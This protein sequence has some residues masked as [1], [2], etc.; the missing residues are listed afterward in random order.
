MEV[1]PYA[2]IQSLKEQIQTK[3]I[4]PGDEQLFDFEGQE[5][6]QTVLDYFRNDRDKLNYLPLTIRRTEIQIWV[7]PQNSEPFA[8][9][10]KERDLGAEVKKIIEAK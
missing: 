5:M 9:D 10:V 4:V 3:Y 2:T 8:L 7:Q 1:S 6:V